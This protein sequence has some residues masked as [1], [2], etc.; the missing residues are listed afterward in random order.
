MVEP[1]AERGRPRLD[2]VDRHRHDLLAEH[3]DNAVKRAHPAQATPGLLDASPQRIDLGQGKPCGRSAR[4]SDRGF[5]R[6]ARRSTTANRSVA[7][8]E[9]VALKAGLAK[10]PS[11]A[12]GG[13]GAR[14][15][16]LLAPARSERPA[17]G[18]SAPAAA[19]WKNVD[20][21]ARQPAPFSSSAN[22]RARSLRAPA[23]IRA[24]ISSQRSSSRKSAGSA[25]RSRRPPVRFHPRRA[26]AF[27]EVADAADIG[28]ALG[29][30]DHPARLQRVEDVAGL[31][32][33]LIG[34]DRKLGFKRALAFGRGLPEQ[35]E[36]RIGVRDLEIPRRQLALVLRNTSP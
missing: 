35:V 2:P 6:A 3:R 16:D 7:L 23:C 13:A 33:L 14:A 36:Q 34:R 8:L 26:G 19:A 15:L 21:L 31:D 25:G 9:L 17:R 10:K 4:S 12:C 28:L 29:D 5:R 18:R 27:R 22:I 20:R 11:S 1:V 24:G 32:R 30:R